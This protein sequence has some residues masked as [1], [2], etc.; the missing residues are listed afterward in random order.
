LHSQKLNE[1]IRASALPDG[2]M[3]AIRG[4]MRGWKV[5]TLADLGGDE[6]RIWKEQRGD[7]C[8]GAVA[9][10][11]D[12]RQVDSFAVTLVRK[13][14][15]SIYQTLVLLSKNNHGSYTILTLDRPQ[16]TALV[17][18]VAKLPPGKYSSWDQAT[19]IEAKFEVISYEVIEAGAVA[20]Y[21]T[22]HEYKTLNTSE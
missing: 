22:G 11:F 18:V 12:S 8:P 9:G 2:A 15:N 20:F 14:E 1:E 13:R 16:R 5:V 6:R 19:N 4:A 3:Q 7:Q 21:W 10:H 17:S